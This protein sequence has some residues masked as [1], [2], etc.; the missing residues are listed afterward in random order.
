VVTC[1]ARGVDKTCIEWK[2]GKEGG[3]E[4]KGEPCVWIVGVKGERNCAL[5][6]HTKGHAGHLAIPAHGHPPRAFL[7]SSLRFLSPLAHA[8]LLA[9]PVTPS[10]GAS[11]LI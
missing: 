11:F 7:S 6:C 5:L 3:R 1:G 4:G 8:S 9:Y 10:S 2:G